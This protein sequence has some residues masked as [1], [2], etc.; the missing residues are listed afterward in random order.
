[1]ISRILAQLPAS[2]RIALL[3]L[4]VY[5]GDFITKRLV[6]G[7]LGH[8]EEV[9]V[10]PGFFTLV[11]WQN[12]GA[13]W[14]LFRGA[15]GMLAVVAGAAIVVLYLSRHHFGARLPLGQVALGLI[16]G[17]IFGNLTDRLL[18]GHVVDFL[19]FHVQRR[20]GGEAGFPAFNVADSAICIGVALVFWNSL[21]EEP[22]AADTPAAAPSEPARHE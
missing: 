16:F 10:V 13:A 3:A 12:T 19:F 5:G 20:S 21:R 1:M 14:S 11:H 2:A 18:Y 6:L 22:A 8:A 7:F 4:M 15:N 17:G 9:P